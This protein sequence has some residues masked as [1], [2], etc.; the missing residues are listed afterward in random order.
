M[1]EATKSRFSP[2]GTQIAVAVPVLPELANK[3]LQLTAAGLGCCAARAAGGR[4]SVVDAAAS[5]G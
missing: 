1:K 4:R 2:C 5:A 3:T